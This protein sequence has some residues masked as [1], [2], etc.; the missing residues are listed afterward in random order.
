[1]LEIDE[2]ITYFESRILE[3]PPITPLEW[4]EVC[5]DTAIYLRAYKQCHRALSNLALALPDIEGVPGE[6]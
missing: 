6:H 5:T 1:M 3:M 4:K 2:L